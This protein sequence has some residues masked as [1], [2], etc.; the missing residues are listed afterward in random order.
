MPNTFAQKGD[1]DAR[2]PTNMRTLLLL[3]ALGRSDKAMTPTELNATIGLPKQTVHR[4]CA[5]LEAEGFL[6]RDGDGK[7]KGY[8]AARR[9]R[10]MS[11]GLL[12]ASWANISRHQVL[13]E[14]ASTVGE[15]VNYV[16]PEEAGMR[17]LDRVD[18]G[19]SF[20]IQLPIGTHVPFHCTA[21]G[22]VYM[23]SLPPKARSAFVKALTLSE[24]TMKT[25]TS[26]EALMSELKLIAK[27]GYAEDDEEF[28]D[29]M[30]AVAVPIRDMSG[31]YVASLAVHGP[32]QRM[33]LANARDM[34][35]SLQ[36]A[37]QKLRDALFA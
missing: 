29:D 32:T 3:E 24:H 35:P 30:V 12:H 4:L 18:T 8:R 5:T 23:A 27:Q 16:V 25:H 22:K 15:T 14:I 17:Y 20:R 9:S 2:I 1:A 33:S 19:W 26:P 13:S 6:V 11:S 28:L 37:A 10:M 31:R 36:S 21:S 34:L 7:G